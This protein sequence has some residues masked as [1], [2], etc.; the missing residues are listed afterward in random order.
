VAKPQVWGQDTQG[1]AVRCKGHEEWSVPQPW[2]PIYWPKNQG[3]QGSPTWSGRA[4]LGK[5]APRKPNHI[6]HLGLELG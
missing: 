4:L 1:A 2:R 3:W 6:R 5:A